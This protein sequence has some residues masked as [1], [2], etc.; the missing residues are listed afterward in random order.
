MNN[1]VVVDDDKHGYIQLIKLHAIRAV[2]FGG[3]AAKP[4]A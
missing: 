2:K 4:T 3:E 1:K